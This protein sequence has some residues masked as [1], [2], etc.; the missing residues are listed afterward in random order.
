V[1]GE[2]KP[3]E[4]AAPVVA[5][6]AP[7]VAAPVVAA[8]PPVAAPKAGDTPAAPVLGADPNAK[9]GEPA[10][11]A[12]AAPDKY[13]FK[14]PEGQAL[15]AVQ[16]EAYSPL[17][18]ELGLSQE[19]AQKLIDKSFEV[20][21]KLIEARDTAIAQEIAKEDAVKVKAT[22]EDPEFGGDKFEASAK[23]ANMALAKFGRPG[24]AKKLLDAGLH[25]DP[26][27]VHLLWNVGQKLGESIP[28]A[29][30]D[31]SAQK[32]ALTSVLYPSM[33]KH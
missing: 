23:I 25:S 4:P 28:P 5:P 29:P 24:L 14:A 18:K 8:A 21:P 15:D 33:N 26:D 13:E 31:A 2:I 19:N 6:A 1:P 10:K 20:L 9:P 16:I 12:V 7:V 11:P 22:R 3:A 32:P 27:M 30:G 17:F